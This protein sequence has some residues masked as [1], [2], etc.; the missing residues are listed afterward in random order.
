MVVALLASLALADALLGFAPPAMAQATDPAVRVW[1]SRSDGLRPG[2][3]V[4]VYVRMRTDGYL[5]VL[6]AEPDGRVRV[7]FPLDPYEDNFVRGAED[8][9]VRGRGDRDAFRIYERRGEGTVYAAFSPDPFRFDEFVRADHWDYRLLDTWRIGRDEDP[10]AELTA[11][12]QRMATDRFD[13]D[14]VRYTVGPRVAYR[15]YVRPYL[16]V[17]GGSCFGSPCWPYDSRFRLSIGIGLHFGQPYPLYYPRYRFYGGGF[18]FDPFS[19]D[20]FY[21]DR[22]FFGVGVSYYDPFYWPRYA[23]WYDPFWYD[24]FWHH[25]FW[26]RPYGYGAS[27][28]VYRYSPI[29]AGPPVRWV[30]RTQADGGLTIAYKESPWA[31]VG[32]GLLGV[33]GEVRR[34]TGPAGAD[35]VVQTS[36]PEAPARLAAPRREPV[37][38]TGPPLAVPVRAG[39]PLPVPAGRESGA[40]PIVRLRPAGA[41][42]DADAGAPAQP[43][44]RAIERPVLDPAPRSARG[45]PASPP[46]QE[47]RPPQAEGPR[48][49]PPG[50]PARE[51]R[52]PEDARTPPQI[53]PQ[54]RALPAGGSD[55]IREAQS[56]P[57]GI[58]PWS[59]ARPTAR[60][61]RGDEPMGIRAAPR[62][63]PSRAP[64]PGPSVATPQPR[65]GGWS[66]PAHAS[67][68]GRPSPMTQP[69][70]SIRAGPSSG[71]FRAITPPRISTP[72]LRAAP[73]ARAGGTAVPRVRR[74]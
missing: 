19:W 22:F 35:A 45:V 21:C 68:G 1:L 32:G 9:E 17:Y 26:Y 5:L 14:F 55:R 28:V 30:V 20:P 38:R 67:P 40:A 15:S 11:L 47:V 43:A 6:H 53:R 48:I 18:C 59:E 10:E 56:P 13:Y 4:R 66:W 63:T 39:A 62:G 7:L 23:F 61:A 27:W 16:G 31:G 37:E 73:P 42:S 50:S 72:P 36:A 52:P 54:A 70:P 41:R 74:P 25:P 69:A 33:P 12:V 24:P 44:T 65:S 3:R 58:V 57:I 34:R 8:L 29:Y 49:L 51:L 64:A 46:R 60:P 71:G 2:D